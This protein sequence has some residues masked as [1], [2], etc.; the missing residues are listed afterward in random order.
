MKR[1]LRILGIGL[2]T[3]L[4]I[5]L[6]GFLVWA[7]TPYRPEARAIESINNSATQ[8][9]QNW[10]IFN[11]GEGAPTKGL[12]LYPGGRVDYRAYAPQAEAVADA[13]FK[14]VLLPMP[15]NFAFLGTNRADD[16][17][18]AF[19]DI[20]TWAVGG[21]S[22]GG[23]MAA[24]YVKNPPS[25]VEG[26]ILW[27]AYPADNNDLSG[28]DLEVLSIYASNDEVASLEEIQDSKTRLPE[29]TRFVEI[30]GGNHAGFGW[31]GP[32]NGDGILEISKISQQD[33]I[34]AATV[35]FLQS[36]GNR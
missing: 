20:T 29:D 18:A 34:V 17:I 6:V 35:A 12:I 16:V 2:L 9:E 30:E 19:P 28:T 26:L 15:L 27:A 10:L 24:E 5:G 33:Q 36:L 31:Y 32:Q 3:I 22:L 13:G 4:V 1:I 21:H 23:A 25:S 11:P 7:E 8:N 14:V